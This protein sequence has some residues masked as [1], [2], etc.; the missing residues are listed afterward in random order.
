MLVK[1]CGELLTPESHD[2]LGTPLS[3]P[4][5][6]LVPLVEE[7]LFPAHVHITESLTE[8]RTLVGVKCNPPDPTS[9]LVVAPETNCAQ[10]IHSENAA[11]IAATV[12]FLFESFILFAK[13]EATHHILF[14]KKNRNNLFLHRS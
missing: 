6:P 1:E 13:W 5:C 14:P 9:T 11:T 2:P 4:A 8:I 3:S 12:I 7:W 10:P